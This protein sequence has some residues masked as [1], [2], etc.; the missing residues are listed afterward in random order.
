MHRKLTDY[1]KTFADYGKKWT[2]YSK[3]IDG[4]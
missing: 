1:D 4:L 3:S 2:E